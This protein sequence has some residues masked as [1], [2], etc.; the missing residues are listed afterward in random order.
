MR[1]SCWSSA[2]AC[3]PRCCLRSCLGAR[4]RERER[5]RERGRGREREGERESTHVRGRAPK[6]ILL[7]STIILL[8]SAIILLVSTILLPVSTSGCGLLNHVVLPTEPRGAGT[9]W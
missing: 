8:V 5:E 9:R 6:A 4:A 7:V 1:Y 3:W 2:R